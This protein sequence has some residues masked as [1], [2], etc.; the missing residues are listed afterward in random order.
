MTGQVEVKIQD[1]IGTINFFHPQSNSLPGTLLRKLAEE[2]TKLGNNSDVKVIVLRSE[3][4]KAFCGG[5]SFDELMALDTFEK[6]KYFFSGFA[7]VIN[8]MRKVPQFVIVRVQGKAVGGGVGLASAAD[9]VLA[10][11]AASIKF[12]ST[13]KIIVDLPVGRVGRK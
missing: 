2:I 8:A 13:W 11:D 6:G 12:T 1:G 3:G 4:E 10:L 7:E 5:A 9:Y